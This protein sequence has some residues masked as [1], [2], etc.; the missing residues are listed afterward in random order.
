MQDSI[1]I[2]SQSTPTFT[3]TEPFETPELDLNAP[4]PLHLENETYNENQDF[5]IGDNNTNNTNKLNNTNCIDPNTTNNDGEDENINNAIN[6]S[7]NEAAN[8]A[9]NEVTNMHWQQGNQQQ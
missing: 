6:K 7:I 2:Y 9:A 1:N 4:L 8:N 5:Y 3:P